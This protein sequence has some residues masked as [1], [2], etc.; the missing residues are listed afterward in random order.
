MPHWLP[1]SRREL[2][3]ELLSIKQAQTNLNPIYSDQDLTIQHSYH[4]QSSIPMQSYSYECL[5]QRTTIN[6]SNANDVH[7]WQATQGESETSSNQMNH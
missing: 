6:V 7:P 3:R 5:M 1:V 2:L 4:S